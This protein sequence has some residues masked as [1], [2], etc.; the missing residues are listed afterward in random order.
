MR[1]SKIENYH[2]LNNKQQ[3]NNFST[4]KIGQTPSFKSDTLI[5]L[6]GKAVI[7]TTVNGIKGSRLASFKK[8]FEQV[9]DN[10]SKFKTD[11]IALRLIQLGKTPYKEDHSINLITFVANIFKGGIYTLEEIKRMAFNQL[12]P[13]LENANPTMLAAK[14][15][16]VR[17]MYDNNEYADDNFISGFK[18]LPNK[19]FANLKQDLV[20]KALYLPAAASNNTTPDMHF[21]KFKMVEALNDGTGVHDFYLVKNKAAIEKLYTISQAQA[22][23]KL[24]ETKNKAFAMYSHKFMFDGIDY[25]IE[26]EKNEWRKLIKKHFED[27]VKEAD[28]DPKK[29]AKSLNIDENWASEIFKD[30]DTIEKV[31]KDCNSPESRELIKK[32]I[33]EKVNVKMN[34]INIDWSDNNTFRNCRTKF[35]SVMSF[36]NMLA[37]EGCELKESFL[38]ELSEIIN[39]QFEKELDNPFTTYTGLPGF[40]DL[41]DSLAKRFLED[42]FYNVPY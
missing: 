36:L 18:Q 2:I 39:K 33:E 37:V 31:K 25:R 8:G 6:G 34:V 35:F 22:V 21:Y 29:L 42:H 14:K 7:L 23:N 17:S 28:K 24:T 40:A 12:F 27:A 30:F 32:R 4:N 13:K 11:D 26:P 19:Y 41:E 15:E 5:Y 20:N 3:K 16:F 38:K 10:P 1:V 9:I